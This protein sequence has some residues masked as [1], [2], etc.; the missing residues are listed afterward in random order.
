MRIALKIEYDGRPFCGWQ[1]QDN[2]P[3]IQAYVE[4][5]LTTVAN[6]PVTVICAGRTDAG[7]HALQQVVHFDTTAIRP[8][9]AWVFGCNRIL[10]SA[11]AIHWAKVMP[12]DFHARFS[13]I[14]R[15]YRYIIYNHP[16]RPALQYG[17]V[18]WFCHPLDVELMQQ[19]ANYLLGENDFTSFRSVAC[20]A[21]TPMRNVMSIKIHR[22]QEKVIIDIKANAF[23]HHM[24]RNIVG[25]LLEVG[26][27][28]RAPI[29]VQ[30][31]L[32]AR[33]RRCASATAKPDG[34]YLAGVEYE[35]I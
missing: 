21:R 12:D 2:L 28:R 14:A 9:R 35:K 3:T 5:A 1:H 26:V 11:I 4:K 30:Q 25:V 15:Q 32:Q 13:A 6:H 17:L 19:G 10:P 31:V 20:Q 8:E 29:W 34:L 27:K 16:V 24:V 22:E 7:V 23:L 33:D 18:T